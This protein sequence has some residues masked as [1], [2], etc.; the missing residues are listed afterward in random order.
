[1]VLPL[2][3][4]SEIHR[5]LMEA[6]PSDIQAGFAATRPKP[7]TVAAAL[8]FIRNQ[9]QP[10]S[11]AAPYWS[12]RHS[13]DHT[14]GI[15][16]AVPHDQKP[17]DAFCETLTISQR[18]VMQMLYGEGAIMIGGLEVFPRHTR[19]GDLKCPDIADILGISTQRVYIAQN[20]L[21]KKILSFLQTTSPI[22]RTTPNLQK[23]E[24][25]RHQKMDWES[26][27][28]TIQAFYPY[29][30]IL[31]RRVGRELARLFRETAEYLH[32]LAYATTKG[33]V[34]FKTLSTD[35]DSD[36]FFD[37]NTLNAESQI[38]LTD[39]SISFHACNS[40]IAF[41]EQ[42]FKIITAVALIE[43]KSENSLE[44]EKALRKLISTTT[45][46]VS[47]VPSK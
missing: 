11:I 25:A 4:I 13:S 30:S 1:M 7:E 40:P 45:S 18:V 34:S 35:L 3:P 20:I 17:W 9:N 29:F 28:K 22:A 21:I 10:L 43:S 46:L 47:F 36:D 23:N 27:I 24:S 14:S 39:H 16:A 19:H 6:L 33:K 26:D 41:L 42:V 38:I 5:P 8:I 32:L 37:K 31:E 12:D 15:F 2:A 44:S